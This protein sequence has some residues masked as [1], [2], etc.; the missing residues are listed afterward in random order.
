ML[1][2]AVPLFRGQLGNARFHSVV[3]RRPASRISRAPQLLAIRRKFHGKQRAPK[4]EIEGKDT[5]KDLEAATVTAA[6]ILGRRPAPDNE[7]DTKLREKGFHPNTVEQAIRR[8]KELGLQ[9]N[10]EYAEVFIRSK[11]R[12]SRWGPTRLKRELCLRGLGQKDIEAGMIAVFGDSRGPVFQ[13][14]ESPTEFFQELVEKSRRHISASK[15][16]PLQTRRRRM[17]GWLQRRG[18]DWDV[19]SRVLVE[20]GLGFE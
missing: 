9:S 10:A 19:V 12:Q 2:R 11:W 4:V 15:H 14:D 3:L 16:L 17:V 6:R 13:E 1:P 5:A 20:L 8:V 18:Y 7:L